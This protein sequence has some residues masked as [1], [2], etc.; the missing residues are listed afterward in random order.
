MHK[1]ST[2]KTRRLMKLNRQKAYFA[3][4]LGIALAWMLA[5]CNRGINMADEGVQVL[6]GYQI[7][8]GAITYLDYYVPVAPLGFMIQ[9]GLIKLFGFHL[10]VGR[11]YAVL[12][13]LLLVAMALDLGR[14]YLKFPAS[15]VPGVL[16]VFFG[17]AMGGFPHYNLDAG[18]FMFAAFYVACIYTEKQRPSLV[19][20]A[21]LLASFAACS[22]QSM[23]VTA[24]VVVSIAVFTAHEKGRKLLPPL[25]AGAVGLALPVVLLFVRLARSHALEEAGS[26]LFGLVGMKRVVLFRIL[27][28][29]AALILLSLAAVYILV[30]LGRRKPALVPWL[31]FAAAAGAAIFMALAPGPYPESF[32]CALIALSLLVFVRPED[33]RGF[34][35]LARVTWLLF[36]IFSALSGLDLSHLLLAAAGAPL[37]FGLL[38][39]KYWKASGP[40]LLRHTV[41]ALLVMAVGVG[42]YMNLA[43]PHMRYLMHPR[44]QATAKIDLPGLEL[45]RAPPGKARQIENTANWIKTHTGKEER[46]FVYPWDLLLYVFADRMPATYD[47]FL[48]FE[49]FDKST[50]ERVVRDLERKKPKVA[51]VA[52]E[53]ERF[54]HQAFAGQAGMIEGYLRSRYKKAARF[55]DYQL[56][57]RVYEDKTSGDQPP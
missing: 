22:K 41:S 34:W 13:G 14:R 54:R 15:L 47:T 57:V 56:M 23:A 17:A 32:V 39:Q 40:A 4:V 44:W 48:Y 49:I 6:Y 42:A 28:P 18:F 25:L 37:F 7:A 24:A 5:L 26:A 20:A 10:I 21:A 16:Y 43:V 19:F 2:I 55:G 45:I 38:V 30:R 11:L 12:Q 8:H 1:Q 52:M 46:I 53:D 31:F 9:S 51:V 36:F 50:A 29:A 3:L 27:P 33:N 35:M